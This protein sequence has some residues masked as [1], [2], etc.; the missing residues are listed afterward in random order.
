MQ[1]LGVNPWLSI[2]SSPRM[3]I[4]A[5][6]EGRQDKNFYI[7]AGLTGLQA[8]L[9]FYGYYAVFSAANFLVFLL[10]ALFFA[11]ILGTFWFYFCAYLL[12]VTG[13][14]LNGLASC[15]QL[16]LVFA[17]SKVPLL[18]DLFTWLIVLTFVSE[19][20]AAPSLNGAAF[21]FFNL[22]FAISKIWSLV[23]LIQGIREVQ[24]FSILQAIANT[25]IA[26][27]LFVACVFIVVYFVGLV[28]HL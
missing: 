21:F 2:W 27:V 12:H 24:N 8:F 10:I 3:T 26:Y 11:P 16:R 7:L 13:R 25:A 15:R 1:K 23:I 22:I 28:I 19:Y 14:W 20:F 6:I 9:F 5:L 18:I 4:R 17:W